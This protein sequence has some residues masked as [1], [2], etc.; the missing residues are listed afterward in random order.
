MTYFTTF[1][2]PRSPQ[3][4]LRTVRLIAGRPHGL[5]RLLVASGR[6]AAG[7]LGYVHLHSGDEVVRVLAGEVV[8]RIDDERQTCHEGDVAV[9]PP[10]TLHGLRAVDDALVE[11]IAER[12][13]G[14]FFPV[15]QPDGGRRLVEVYRADSPWNAPPPR[16]GGYTSDRELAAILRAIDVEV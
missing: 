12:D 1:Q 11:I 16:P 4:E 8:I 3:P 5:E 13:M 2:T 14:T 7:Y 10:N 9:I 6:M 15:R